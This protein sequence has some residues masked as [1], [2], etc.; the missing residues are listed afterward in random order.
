MLPPFGSHSASVRKNK[1]ACSSLTL[2]AELPFLLFLHYLAHRSFGAEHVD[3]VV[4]VGEVEG[5]VAF[6]E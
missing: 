5:V 3:T 2:I 4:Q 1:R 6:P